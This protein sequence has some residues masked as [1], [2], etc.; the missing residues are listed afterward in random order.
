VEA[1]V[2]LELADGVRR[3]F[4]LYKCNTRQAT[5]TFDIRTDCEHTVIGW[6]VARELGI[7]PTGEA[8]LEGG[9]IIF[10][11]IER[12]PLLCHEFDECTVSIGR[13]SF[14]SKL[15]IPMVYGER[16]LPRYDKNRL[17][18]TIC[19]VRLL[20]NGKLVITS[21]VVAFVPD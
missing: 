16:G 5:G 19:I 18:N 6:D 4:C 1:S 12:Q 3:F 15:Y 7:H 14:K 17:R 21:E 10:Q 2:G 8:L 9:N 11:V 13:K 20:T